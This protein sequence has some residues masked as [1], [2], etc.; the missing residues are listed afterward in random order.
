MEYGLAKIA[1]PSLDAQRSKQ[2]WQLLKR[3]H[4]GTDEAVNAIKQTGDV[5]IYHG[6][7]AKN[8]PNIQQEGLQVGPF[9]EFGQGVF[10]GDRK[11]A[12]QY[13]R[14]RVFQEGKDYEIFNAPNNEGKMLNNQDGSL[15][16]FARQHPEKYQVNEGQLVRMALPSELRGTDTLYPDVS[17]AKVFDLSE[18]KTLQDVAPNQLK[19][20]QDWDP[21]LQRYASM[22]Q[23]YLRRATPA[24]KED[25]FVQVMAHRTGRNTP[26]VIQQRREQF[27][28]TGGPPSMD[29]WLEDMQKD[30]LVAPRNAKEQQQLEYYGKL[31]GKR[32]FERSNPDS[33]RKEMFFDQTALPPELI[34]PV[35]E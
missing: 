34:R 24:Q 33:F 11:T 23:S 29:V 16:A 15:A 27:R 3:L 4:G 31:R 19:Y 8:V 18:G 28:S 10:V 32:L 21:S 9:R 17:K 25:M 2:Y 7:M 14:P 1:M 5:G 6:T 30:K 13:S 35:T 26:E 22:L 20:L 12:E